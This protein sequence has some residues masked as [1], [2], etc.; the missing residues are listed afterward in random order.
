MT[1]L[2]TH[3]SLLK[4][5][6]LQFAPVMLCGL[7]L[8]GCGSTSTV[9][10]RVVPGEI[11]VVTVVPT[12]DDRLLAT[13]QGIPGIKV[14]MRKSQTVITSAT[15]TPDGSFTMKL[16]NRSTGTRY[17]IVATG[18][19]IFPVRSTSY[20]PQ[21]GQTLLIIADTRPITPER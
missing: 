12:N 19:G 15:T 10:G 14:E 8:V 1:T 6:F 11:G 20:P 5:A 9:R 16:D 13:T 17:D 2:Q 7:L 21:D 18:P 3:R 4:L